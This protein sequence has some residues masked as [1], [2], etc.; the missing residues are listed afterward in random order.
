MVYGGPGVPSLSRIVPDAPRIS[1]CRLAL[2]RRAWSTFWYRVKLGWQQQAEIDRLIATEA[3]AWLRE[4]KDAG[5][6]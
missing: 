4:W 5:R 1:R 3:R 6:T 2:L